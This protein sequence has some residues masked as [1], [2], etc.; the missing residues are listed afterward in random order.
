MK[1]AMVATLL[2]MLA[3][4]AHATI[5]YNIDRTIGAGSVVG[6]I[7]TDGTLGVLST[8]NITN[9]S[10]TLSSPNLSSGSPD[11]IT[12][13]GGRTQIVGIALTATPTRLFFDYGAP[14][15]NLALFQGGAF[16]NYWCMET[17]LCSD[18]TGPAESI[19]FGPFG[20]AGYRAESVPGTGVVELT[21]APVPEPTTLALLGA[22]LVAVRAR[23]RSS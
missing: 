14:A 12:F 13:L 1:T 4:A 22:G 19:G 15:A 2:A 8:P 18:Y 5:I 11:V 16:D 17:N 23:R 21:G 20:S 10:F 9:W 7:E 3:T 6:F